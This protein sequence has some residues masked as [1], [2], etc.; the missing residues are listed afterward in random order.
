MAGAGVGTRCP[1]PAAPGPSP[2]PPQLLRLVPH[3]HTPLHGQSQELPARSRLTPPSSDGSLPKPVP[4]PTGPSPARSAS[5]GKNE[6]TLSKVHLL[7]FKHHYFL[8]GSQV[9]QSDKPDV[10]PDLGRT[11]FPFY[12]SASSCPSLPTPFP[13]QNQFRYF[14]YK[15]C[16]A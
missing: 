6:R 2:R 13:L 14:R 15:G 9:I 16:F 4:I 3:H 8:A 12:C 5:S 1:A 7:T 10:S 11:L